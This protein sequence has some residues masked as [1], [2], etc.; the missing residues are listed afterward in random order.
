MTYIRFFSV[1]YW[2]PP[3]LKFGA[4]PSENP[5]CAP[6]ILSA[7]CRDLLFPKTLANGVTIQ[8]KLRRIN[9]EH[10]GYIKCS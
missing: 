5:R 9:K 10:L 2:F 4:L 8:P 3:F 1:L 6:A 7:I